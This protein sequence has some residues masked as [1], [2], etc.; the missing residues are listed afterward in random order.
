[1]IYVLHVQTGRELIIRDE[2]RR[3]Y[4]PAMVPREICLERRR[5]KI[6]RRERT[7]MPGYVFIDIVLDLNT[8][9]MI[10]KI[11]YVIKFLDDGNPMAL[12]AKEAEYITWLSN[13]GKPL[14]P[15]KLNPDG[16]VMDG[17]LKSYEQNIVSMN[18]RARR[19]KLLIDLMGKQ[20]EV[21]LSVT[22]TVTG[23]SESDGNV[24]YGT[25]L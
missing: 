2:L 24:S 16:T 20:H 19:A 22:A 23:S 7:I 10:R 18:K 4:I 1:M 3:K 13:G 5:G 17:P 21:S 12:S 14:E 8:Y 6:G 9:Y 11:P 15:S 25:L